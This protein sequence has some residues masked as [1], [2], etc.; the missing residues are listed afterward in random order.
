MATLRKLVATRLKGRASGFAAVRSVGGTNEDLLCGTVGI[1]IVVLA[2]LNV[3]DDTL[4]V[5]LVGLTA[6]A[7][8]VHFVHFYYLTFHCME[9]DTIRDFES[10]SLLFTDTHLI[11]HF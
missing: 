7:V 2:V 1:A 8:L 3:A 4:N 9:C 10:T 5:L 11:I 6:V